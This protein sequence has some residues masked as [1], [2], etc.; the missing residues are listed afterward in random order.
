MQD[1]ARPKYAAACIEKLLDFFEGKSILGITGQ[2]CRRYVKWRGELGATPQ[3]ARKDLE[4]LQAALNFYHKE[5]VLDAVPAV[6]LPA[7]GLPREEWLTR[8]QVAALLWAAWRRPDSRHLC[9]YVL[10]AVYTG[11]RTAAILDLRW[12]PSPTSGYVDLTRGVFY[13]RGSRVK[14]TKKRRPPA[15]L[16]WR[17]AAHMRRWQR[18]DEADG[19]THVVHFR[20][21]PVQSLKRSWHH[22]REAAGISRAHVMYCLKHTAA[23]W[24][25]QRGVD[26]W[27]AAGYLG[28]QV[29]KCCSA[30]TGITTQTFSR[31]LPGWGQQGD[32]NVT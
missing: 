20:G 28:D 13:R 17:L 19:V 15:R 2:S 27:E 24:L 11:T 4:Y 23:T 30:C 3:T 22:A 31:T 10:I 7:N 5:Y 32:N 9:R 16:H 25:M 6:T 26:A 21:K 29:W 18:R 1:H 8:S 12:L 14:E